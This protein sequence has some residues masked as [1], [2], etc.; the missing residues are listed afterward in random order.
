M[1]GKA[2]QETRGFRNPSGHGAVGDELQWKLLIGDGM[3]D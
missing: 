2:K 1:G 3:G